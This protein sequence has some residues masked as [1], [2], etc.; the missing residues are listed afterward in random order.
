MKVEYEK[1]QL[2]FSLSAL[3]DGLSKEELDEVVDALS[4][5]EGIIKGVVEQVLDGW[6]ELSSCGLRGATVVEPHC[7]LEWAT[8]EIAKRSGEVALKEIER[9]E[10]ELARRQNRNFQ[11]SSENHELQRA[12]S[13]ARSGSYGNL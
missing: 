4:C 1:G 9:L 12:L 6:T 2:S 8:R 5:Q 7:D 13:C 3:L 11:L 10:E